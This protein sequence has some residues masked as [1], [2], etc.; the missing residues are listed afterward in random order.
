VPI[1][2]VSMSRTVKVA[3]LVLV[4]GLAPVAIGAAAIEHEST[5]HSRAELDQALSSTADNERMALREYFSR[6]RAIDLLM[7]R[8]PAFEG[9]Y[10]T[11]GSLRE[12]LQRGGGT[13]EDMNRALQYLEHLYPTSIGEACVI[14]RG[15]AEAARAVRGQR[16]PR[17]DLSPDESGN[18]FFTPTF[19]TPVGQVYQ[20]KPYVSPDTKEWVISNST[21]LPSGRAFVHFEITVESFR[22]AAAEMAKQQNADLLVIDARS[23]A[24][25]FDSRFPQRMGSP[26]GRPGDRRFEEIARSGKTTGVTTVGE[27]RAGFTRL[28]DSRNANDWYVIAAKPTV[29]ASFLGGLGWWLLAIVAALVGVGALIGRRYESTASKSE[30]VDTVRTSAQ[31]LAAVANELRAA[32]QETQAA[33]TEQS[34]AVAETSATIE[35]LAAAATSIADNAHAV[36]GAASQTGETIREMQEKVDS[37]A[38]RSLSLG[39]RS[40]KIGEILELI[41]GIAEQTNLL[42]L[43][44]AI[45]AARAGE[46]GRGFAVVAAEVRKL[47]ERSIASTD[48]IK[49][50]IG[51]VQDET[52]ATIMATEQ[53]SRQAREVAE[54]MSSTTSM[55]DES[56]LATQ[57]QKSAAEQVA[58]A[59]LQ[60]RQAADQLAADQVQ[61]AATAEQLEQLVSELEGTLGGS[62]H[63][64]NGREQEVTV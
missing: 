48:S 31:M 29:A 14:D 36:S 19:A 43:N 10:A 7:S 57:Q 63:S 15:G 38:E 37:I 28:D 1:H 53:S 33:T 21:Q 30:L 52:N 11:P 49:Q 64:G 44:A 41:D 45:E 16:A 8:N 35:E 56:I 6:A 50:I 54:L 60:I 27:L 55:L 24:V 23:G 62:R 3:L 59:M 40:Q 2:R 12:K 34:S 9:F 17:K 61:R 18:P 32:A 4:I 26:L 58:S 20:A 51:A 42:A 47:A 22:R 39:E 25:V 46:A 5:K 13:V